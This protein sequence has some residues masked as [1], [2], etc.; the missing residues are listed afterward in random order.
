MP[1]RPTRPPEPPLSDGVVTLR[2]WTREDVTAI[3]AACSDPEIPRWLDTVPQPYGEAEARAY[4]AYAERGWRGRGAETPFAVVDAESGEVLGSCG[5]HWTDPEQAVAEVGYW[6]RREARGRGVAT[7]A[8]RLVAGWVLGTLHYE[9]LQL[10]AD[11]LNEASC[12]VAE[13]AGFTREG[14][15]RS[16]RFSPRQGRRTDVAYY[17]LLRGEL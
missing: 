16:A 13:R 12:R 7:R 17:S 3:A 4:V 10:R 6:V 2:P 15:L 8:T 1:V 9:R 14:V 11:P 5:V